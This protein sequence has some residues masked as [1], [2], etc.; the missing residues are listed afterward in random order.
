MKIL[1]FVRKFN[2]S[3]HT[4]I[5]NELL[6]LQEKG[7]QVKVVCTQRL[8]SEMYPFPDVEVVPLS[9]P[10]RFLSNRLHQLGWRLNY[11]NAPLRKALNRIIEDF[12][13]D[14]I[15]CQFGPD[16]LYFIDNYTGKGCPVFIHFHGYD[17]SVMLRDK[18]YCQRLDE[19]FQRP[20]VF[21]FFVSNYLLQNVLKKKI[22]VPQHF[23]LYCGINTDFFTYSK[24]P[25]SREKLVFLQVSSL[26]EKKGHPFTLR[27][28]AQW[29]AQHPE[30]QWEFVITGGGPEEEVLRKLAENL[31]ITDHLRFV[32]FVNGDQAKAL[33]E[34]AH[35]FLHHSVTAS[36]DGDMEGIPNAVMEAMAM[37]LPVLST[38]HSGIP[39]LVE[40][41]VNGF[42][43]EEHNIE[44]YAERLADIMHWQRQPKNRE[45]IMS[46]FEQK[47]HATL[48]HQYYLQAVKQLMS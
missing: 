13:P 8:F 32:G 31:G 9:I 28:L 39:E 3:T 14:V 29:S 38:W 40:D 19:V 45:K 43:V 21:P 26:K 27:A 24:E 10:Q 35:I 6:G 23:I 12:K 15:H 34:E 30:Q 37:G 47:Q 11:R 20:D 7:L 36:K 41:G 4:F 42:L 16:G 17:A 18:L 1:A 44:E 25:A 22:R 2:E 33:L 5:Y 46:L 48:L